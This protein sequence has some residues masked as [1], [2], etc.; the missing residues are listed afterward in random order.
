MNFKN[1][2]GSIIRSHEKDVLKPL[3]TPWGETLDTEHVWEEYPRPQ[4]VRGNYTILN[5]LWDYAILPKNAKCTQPDNYCGKILV[6]FSPESLLSGV[7]RQLKP[8]EYLYYRRRFHLPSL[9]VSRRM[10]LHFGAVDQVAEVWVN[11]HFVLEHRGGYL[12]FEADITPFITTGDNILT[13]R[14]SD[15]SETADFSRGKQRL[16]R[17]GIFY[18][19]QSGIWQTV[20]YEW[21]PL[22][23]VQKL[24]LKPD[25][26]LAQIHIS[27][28]MANASK[29]TL[30]S[31]AEIFEDSVLTASAPL[32]WTENT[33]SCTVSLPDF[34]R[35]SPESPFLYSLKIYAGEDY[36]E[37]YFA[38]RCF[39]IETDKNGYPCFCLNHRPYFLY[40]VLDQAYWPDGLYTAPCDEAFLYD[41]QTAKKLGFNMIRKHIKVEAARWYYHCDRTGMI[42]WQDMVNGGTDY[43]SFFVGHIPTIFSCSWNH[44]HDHHY[45]LFSRDSKENRDE[46]KQ[47]CLDTIETLYNVPSIAVWGPFNE[48]WGQFD[49]NEVTA[50]IRQADATRLI[51]QA[52]G[53][54]DQGGGDFISEHNYFRTLK[55]HA[56][57]TK[58]QKKQAPPRSFVISEFGGYACHIA[59]HASLNRIFGYRKYDTVNAL[60]DAYNKLLREELVPL[61]EK[62]LSGAVYTQLTDIE[63]EVNGLITYD[64]KIVKIPFPQTSPSASSPHENMPESEKYQP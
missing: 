53:W 35:W 56:I 6:P 40:G 50:L 42:V 31:Y 23:F 3:F 18:T 29:P 47:E 41:I 58:E 46:W 19:A 2:L 9:P 24:T 61:R 25:Y 62:G 5:G 32:E 59:A 57:K 64:R 11:G 4:M 60:A 20:W 16:K 55:S 30:D 28:T 17:G 34:K 63:E 26:D 10:L 39:S 44:I 15:V 8:D 37:S 51:D 45:K 22:Q 7:G 12:P 43:K 48:G 21:V 33:L 27:L 14:V 13:L 54:Y 38:M 36:V 52:S 49:A 1:A